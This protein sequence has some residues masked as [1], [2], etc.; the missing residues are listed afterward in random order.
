MLNSLATAA[1][2]DLILIDTLDGP[3]RLR[4]VEGARVGEREGR[5]VR[6]AQSEQYAVILQAEK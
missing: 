5:I 4:M 1:G 3:N 2:H 6:H